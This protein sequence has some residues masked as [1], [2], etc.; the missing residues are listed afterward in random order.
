MSV[1]ARGGIVVQKLRDLRNAPLSVQI[2]IWT[3]FLGPVYV[4]DS[5]VFLFIGQGKDTHRGVF[6]F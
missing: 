1:V 6:M 5:P 2:L 3:Y 4:L